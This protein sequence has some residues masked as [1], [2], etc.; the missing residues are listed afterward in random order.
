MSSRSRKKRNN[1]S[2]GN[3]V[4]RINGNGVSLAEKSRKGMGRVYLEAKTDGQENFISSIHRN[5]L[6]VC[7]GP[8][9]TGKTYIAA[10]MAA[11]LLEDTIDYD[12]IVVV[13]PAVVACNEKLGFLPGNLDK[14]MAPFAMPVLYNLAKIV[15]Q[16]KFQSYKQNDMVQVLPMAYMRGLTLDHCV[17]ILDEAQNTTPAQM[18]MFLTRIGEHCKVIIEGDETQSDIHGKN[19]LADAVE[20]LEGMRDVGI[21]TMGADEVIRSRFVSDLMERYPE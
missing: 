10:A 15:G 19:G 18:K 8:A 11:R 21:A 6:T 13:R 20:R 9:G 7:A 17:V 12:H 2:N 16:R 5:K 4:N 1:S 14:K 3:G